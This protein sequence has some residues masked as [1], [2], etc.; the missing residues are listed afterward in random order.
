[1]GLTGTGAPLEYAVNRITTKTTTTIISAS[2]YISTIV[3]S[4]SNAGT[5][6]TCL[7]QNK[8]ATPKILIPN[9]TLSAATTGTPI[10]LQFIEPV[11]MTDGVDII[12]DGVT[13]GVIDIFMT[14]RS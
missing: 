6:W 11:L 2:A 7:I 13:A 9:F 10:L 12:T 5:G 1:M 3:I 4:C 14:Y 8:E